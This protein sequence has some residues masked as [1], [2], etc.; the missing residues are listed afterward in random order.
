MTHISRDSFARAVGKAMAQSRILCSSGIFLLPRNA[1]DPRIH[2]R[3]QLEI[4]IALKRERIIRQPRRV[5]YYAPAARE[6]GGA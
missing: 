2:S 5:I 4:T 6:V 1:L 3:L